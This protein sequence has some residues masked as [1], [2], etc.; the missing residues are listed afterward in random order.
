MNNLAHR[1]ICI[2]FLGSLS[3][4]WADGPGTVPEVV[5]PFVKQHCVDCHGVE[6]Q[7]G[8]LALHVFRDE[9]SMLKARESWMRVLEQLH[10]GNMPPEKH[11]QP[12][13]QEVERFIE[14]VL[15]VFE[16]YDRTAKPDPGRTP[17]RRLNRVEYAN[18]I[19]DLLQLDLSIPLA[20][21]FPP[22]AVTYGF[23]NNA[24]ALKLSPVLLDRYLA[25]AEMVAGRAIR[26]EMADPVVHSA[27][28]MLQ[29]GRKGGFK[30]KLEFRLMDSSSTEPH[31]VG[32]LRSKAP[33]GASG[34]NSILHHAATDD[35]I[36]RAIVY[37]GPSNKAPVRAAMFI[38]GPGLPDYS[39]PEEVGRLAGNIGHRE[40]HPMKILK[41]FDVTA[42]SSDEPQHVEVVVSRAG[43]R[44]TIASMGIALFKPKEDEPPAQLFVK[45]ESEGPLPP[46]SHQVLLA[47][48]PDKPEVEKTREVLE[49]LLPRAF[50][51]PVTKDEIE[52][53]ARFADQ[54][55]EEGLKWEV[56]IQRALMAVL[57]SPKFLFRM[58]PAHRPDE[59]G[60]HPVDEY[61]LA[62]RLSYFLW[63]SMPDDTLFDLAARGELSDNLGT[64]VR[65]MAKDP[66]AMA[67]IDQF[68]LKWLKLDALDT[69]TPDPE[70]FPKFNAALREA[71]HSETRLFLHSILLE[72]RRLSE[73]IEADYTFLNRR[74]GEHYG[75]QDTFGNRNRPKELEKRGQRLPE[76]RLVRVPLQDTERGGVLT[77]AS[78]LTMTS[79]PTRTSPVK[80]GAWVLENILGTTPKPPP[81]DVPELEVPRDLES[82]SVRKQLE[83]H[84]AD[85]ACAGCHAK[86]DPLGFPFEHYDAVGAYRT[87]EGG[88]GIDA[89]GTLPD[90]RKLAGI[91][92]LRSALLDDQDSF[93]QFLTERM[94]IYALGRQLEY[95]DH[96]TVSQIVK[97]A[98]EDGYQLS[99]LVAEVAKSDPFR[100]RRGKGSEK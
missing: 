77:Q 37:A 55:M 53:V 25:S 54:A 94:L 57:C 49:R 84:R 78:I 74:L 43:R 21:D 39:P 91:V 38:A 46:R 63:S 52:A 66:K 2:L 30:G 44:G 9:L 22:D 14:V 60:P 58:E 72:D 15:G 19:R 64:Q 3:Q 90:G 10:T 50:R 28:R 45:L 32:P 42:T 80:R 12:D 26:L 56:G 65:R 100:L 17:V 23:E 16:T 88:Q 62:S 6:K 41:T 33:S 85:P 40:V 36:F 97:A 34:K 96:R 89:G 93:A 51:R 82:A 8:D 1:F 59:V 5:V 67:F 86:I 69:H 24:D 47:A 31:E 71:M 61:H 4:V 79:S 27:A 18:T 70:T 81:P 95:Y 11:P 73:L 29:P 68:A 35:F 75:I 87:K 48:S 7:K 98:S 76:H 92:D 13:T 83:R 20:A 99:R